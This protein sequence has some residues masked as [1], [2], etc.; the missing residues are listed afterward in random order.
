MSGT[1][2]T[3]GVQAES[4]ELSINF[5]KRRSSGWLLSLIRR[6][7]RSS[8]H[9]IHPKSHPLDSIRHERIFPD[10]TEENSFLKIK[11]I[12]LHTPY[13]TIMMKKRKNSRLN[14]AIDFKLIHK[15]LKINIE[16]KVND[17]IIFWDPWNLIFDLDKICS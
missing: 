2:I 8:F 3:S 10:I 14:I 15:R 4:L 16:V 1:Q 5:R 9:K 17:W 11:K 13:P 6:I 7:R 12:M